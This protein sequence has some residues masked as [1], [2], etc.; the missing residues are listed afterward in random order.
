MNVRD[1]SNNRVTN[2]IFL[3]KLIEDFSNIVGQLLYRIGK[4]RLND[5]LDWRSAYTLVRDS[6]DGDYTRNGRCKDTA[7]DLLSY[8]SAKIYIYQLNCN[9]DATSATQYFKDRFP[10]R[11]VL[12][13][14]MQPTEN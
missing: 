10:N 5:F 3:E 8:K 11:C 14:P 12:K 13:Y 6:I 4:N 1:Y 2:N 9:N 7:V